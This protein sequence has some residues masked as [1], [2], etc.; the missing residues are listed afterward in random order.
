MNTTNKEIRI[1]LIKKNATQKDLA[2]KMGVSH[3]TVSAW[4]RFDLPKDRKN[5]ILA[6]IKEM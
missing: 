1:A 5:E 6:V 2:E 3:H 4:L